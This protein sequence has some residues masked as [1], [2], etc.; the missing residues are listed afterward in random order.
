MILVIG[1]TGCIG[2]PLVDRLVSSGHQVKCLWHWGNWRRVP[3]KA[4]ITGGDVRNV[5]SLAQ[6][7]SEDG[8][9]TVINLASIRRE[10]R[11]DTFDDIHITGARNVVEAMKR[12]GI[13]RLISLSCLGA[14]GRS[15]YPMLRSLGKAEDV[16]RS[17]GLNF[18]VL[19]SAA[20][21][22]ENDW[23]TA[24][25]SGASQTMPFV[26]PVPHAGETKL[27]PIWVGDV[28][29]CIDR[30]INLRQTFRQIVQI[31]GP[32][33]LTLADIAQTT[34]KATGRQRRLVRVSSTFT[35]QLYRLMRHVKG[36][37]NLDELEA[38][39]YNRTTEISSVH[40][41]FGF[42]PAKMPTRLA[43]LAPGYAPPPLPVQFKPQHRWSTLRAR[44]LGRSD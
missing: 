15:P 36:A 32:Q 23:L 14:E 30:A 34:L 37:L 20:V 4:A 40:R 8:V 39:S 18:T 29:A 3:L 10:T 43:Y 26:M 28:A 38:L 44:L 24:W 7:M 41:V 6:A 42:A 12:T 11:T 19:K 2:R 35:K 33:S 31:G 9:D 21:Y 25:F 22:G 13:N 5:D 1:P 16:V 17:S 27:Q